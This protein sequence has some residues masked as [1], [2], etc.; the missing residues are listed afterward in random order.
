MCV[1]TY[2]HVLS[3]VQLFG[4]H[5]LQLARLLCP[6]DFP[7]RNTTAGCPFYSRGSSQLMDWNYVPCFSCIG[8]RVLLSLCHLGSPV[9]SQI[10][11]CGR[12]DNM[13][14]QIKVTHGLTSSPLILQGSTVLTLPQQAFHQ[15]SIPVTSMYL[16]MLFTLHGMLIVPFSAQKPW[17]LR[18]REPIT[19]PRN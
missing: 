3:C 5:G 10:Y 18:P 13:K 15:W 17:L 16:N 1:C 2:V 7:G 6:W 14:G 4:P 9:F 12:T 8:R 19:L 11:W